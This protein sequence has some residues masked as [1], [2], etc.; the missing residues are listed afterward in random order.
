MDVSKSQFINFK[1]SFSGLFR[2]VFPLLKKSGV[3]LG[4]EVLK[5]ASGMM[6]DL[7]NDGEFKTSLKN[8]GTEVLN[9]LKKRAYSEMGGEGYK[10]PLRRRK[11]KQSP[12]K[13]VKKQSKSKNK[14]TKKKVVKRKS[15][16]KACKKKRSA[17]DFFSIKHGIH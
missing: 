13:R 1:F 16:S 2:A 3:F 9:N 5:G 4:R 7:G 10:K 6:D 8:R 17:A 14:T 12:K 15:K 11:V